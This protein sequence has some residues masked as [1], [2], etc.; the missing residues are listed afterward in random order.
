MKYYVGIDLGTTNSTICIYDGQTTTVLKSSSQNDVTPSAIYIDKRSRYVGQ[1]AYDQAPFQPNNTALLFKRFMGTSTPIE[2]KA[3]ELK[4]TPV[5]CSSEILKT[6]FSYLPEEIRESDETG[7]VITVPAA[8]NQM[9]KDAT[10]QAA[11]SAGIAKVSLMQE[12]VAA[13][14]SIMK[15]SPMNGTFLIY[16]LGGGTLDIAIAQSM[17]NKVSLLAHGGIAMCGGRDI[18]RKI[19]DNIVLPWLCSTFSLPEPLSKF[20]DYG[21]FV[22]VASW[23]VE[24]AKIELSANEE[25]RIVLSENELRMNDLDDNEMYLD[26]PFDRSQLNI[27]IEDVIAKT[28]EAS[29]EIITNAGITTNDIE[30]IVFIGGPTKY[31]DLRKKVSSELGLPAESNIKIDPMTAVAEGA[32]IFGESIDWST[33][34]HTRKSVREQLDIS[35]DIDIKFNFI[36]RTSNNN[37]Y[38]GIITTDKNVNRFDIQIDSLDTGWTSGKTNVKNGLSIEI[39]LFKNG[40]NHYKIFVFDSL[41]GSVAIPNNRITITKTSATIDAIPASHSVGIEALEKESKISKL[42]YLVHQGDHLPV[43]GQLKFSAASTLKAGDPSS[44][45]FKVWEGEIPHPIQD[46]RPIG[47]MKISGLDF[48]DSIILP[49][50]EIIC[51]YEIMDSGNIVLEVSVPSIQGMFRNDKS[52]YVRQESEQDFLKIIPR[53]KEEANMVNNRIEKIKKNITDSRLEKALELVFPIA[54]GD[55][56]NVDPETAKKNQDLIFDAKKILSQVREAHLT[57]IRTQELNQAQDIYLDFCQEHASET[58]NNTFESLCRTATRA[59]TN[60]NGEFENLISNLRDLTLDVL[61]R[62]DWFIIDRFKRLTASDTF[63]SDKQKFMQLKALGNQSI[64]NDEIETVKNILSQL[65]IIYEHPDTDLDFSSLVN[66][67]A[68]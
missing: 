17:N 14:M 3:L 51:D 39:P 54:Q 13:V 23:A 10:M 6:L 61:W 24:K 67:I 62:Q 9:Q 28:I 4:M 66:I 63:F 29:R 46:N 42:I 49:G 68:E 32:S 30:K 56:E 65:F 16:D 5:E 26:I 58:E 27:L 22:R 12:P 34:D 44:L 47:V 41:G 11:N 37:T 45:N 53:I 60:R 40:E 52:F 35:S 8:F 20:Q 7:T 59:I 50:A 57:E 31:N 55:I 33:E 19:V 21:K 64:N 38:V 18:D 36:S 48:D 43:K 2:I 15:N 1:R 25:T